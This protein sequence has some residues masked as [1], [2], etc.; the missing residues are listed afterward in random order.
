MSEKHYA[1]AVDG[2]S[3]AGKSTLA[4]AVARELHIMY[5]DTGAI[6]RVIGVAAQRRGVDPKDEAAVTAMLPEMDI[7]LKHGA[8]GLKRLYLNCEDVTDTIRLPEVSM[9]ASA[10][11]ALP[12]VRAYLLEMQR[13][14][15]REQSVIMDGRDIGTVVLPD[16]EVKIFLTA[17]SAVRAKRRCLE[18]E[19]RG[20]PKPYDEVLAEIEQRDYN[21]SHRAI[22]PL[23]QAEDAALVD[24][25]ELDFEQ[26]MALMLKTLRENVNA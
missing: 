1:V 9:Y 21:D 22:A 2:P 20:T 7:G 3:G 16:A 10:V 14:F 17:S 13:K 4:K 5:V 15:A 25:S 11:S 8:D 24:T 6:Y 18:L 19:Q 23:R 12:P 26:S